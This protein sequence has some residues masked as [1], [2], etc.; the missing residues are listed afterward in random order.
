[1]MQAMLRRPDIQAT[2]KA[3]AAEPWPTSASEAQAFL[4]TDVN[5]WTKVVRDEG[6]LPPN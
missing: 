5:R 4:A 2:L 1:M 6:I 3:M